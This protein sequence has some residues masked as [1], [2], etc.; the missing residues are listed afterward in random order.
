M[1]AS[2]R[3]KT[4]LEDENENHKPFTL[5]LNAVANPPVV[6]TGRLQTLA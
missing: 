1:K 5:L 2:E 4:D 6:R 3:S